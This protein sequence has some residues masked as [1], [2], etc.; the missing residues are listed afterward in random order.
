MEI[1]RKKCRWKIWYD[2]ENS[3]T[4]ETTRDWDALPK[5][6]VIYVKE[7]G[8]IHM[9]L[10]YY[11]MEEDGSIKSCNRMDIDRYLERDQGIKHVKFGR[12]ADNYVWEKV[13]KEAPLWKPDDG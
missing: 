4:G 13:S 6:G 2:D 3:Y 12:W 5:H 1:R 11:F 9:G 8:L 10:D 7:G